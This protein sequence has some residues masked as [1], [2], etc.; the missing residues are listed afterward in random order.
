MTRLYMSRFREDVEKLLHMDHCLDGDLCIERHENVRILPCRLSE[1]FEARFVYQGGVVSETGAF[2]AGLSRREDDPT[3]SYS[4]RSAYTLSGDESAD[5][6]DELP[7]CFFGGVLIGLFGHTLTETL[8][9]L[10]FVG[11]EADKPELPICFVTTGRVPG[12]FTELMRL[13]GIADRVR[14]V[15]HPLRVGEVFIPEQS[16]YLHER[17]SRS[18]FRPIYARLAANAAV[19]DD[20]ESDLKLYLTRSHLSKSDCAGESTFEEIYA[21]NGYRIV[22][23]EEH[24]FEEQMALLARASC[25]V[26]TIGTLSH[27]AVLFCR[28]TAKLTFLLRENEPEALIPQLVLDEIKDCEISLVDATCNFLPTTH[29]GGVFLLS[30]NEHFAACAQDSGIVYDKARARAD[31]KNHIEKYLRCYAETYGR[32]GYAFKRLQ[33]RDFFAFVSNLVTALGGEQPD[34][35]LFLT[36][37]EKSLEEKAELLEQIVGSPQ[38]IPIDAASVCRSGTSEEATKRILFVRQQG[39][40][41]LVNGTSVSLPEA[42]SL[43]CGRFPKFPRSARYLLPLLYTG[44]TLDLTPFDLLVLDNDSSLVKL[45]PGRYPDFLASNLDAVCCRVSFVKTLEEQYRACH[46]EKSWQSLARAISLDPFLDGIARLAGYSIHYVFARHFLIIRTPLFLRFFA[47]YISYIDGLLSELGKEA[48]LI[49]PMTERLTT[50]YLY[51][52]SVRASV[53]GYCT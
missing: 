26:T 24:S 34:R 10:W 36:P 32:Y 17:V 35:S 44:L 9:R 7:A 43:V 22:A 46:G 21:G 1:F 20:E 52:Q 14:V 12:H 48:F 30:P 37:E 6:A 8:S 41:L 39:E 31:L 49:S 27:M 38:I 50:L 40:V 18:F 3:L 11:T 28:D 47:W 51:A 23:L 15:T 5:S 13:L 45:D 16:L 19:K 53:I 4:V 33:H 42:V 25:I 2:L 29:A